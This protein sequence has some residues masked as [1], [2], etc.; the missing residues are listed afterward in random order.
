MHHEHAIY[1]LEQDNAAALTPPT[2]WAAKKTKTRKPNRIDRVFSKRE[3]EFS[4]QFGS[5]IEQRAGGFGFG[6]P[7]RAFFIRSRKR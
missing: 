1:Q 7:D 5:V 3:Y 2:T 6:T 4:Y